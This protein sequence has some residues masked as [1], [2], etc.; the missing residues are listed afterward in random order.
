MTVFKTVNV[1]ETD[2]KLDLTKTGVNA[3]HVKVN[4][5]KAGSLIW[6]PYELD[7]SKYLKKGEN[8][9][10]LT[11]V[12]NLRNLLGP[13]HLEE[14]EC[15]AVGPAQF[16]KNDSPFYREWVKWNDN[17]CFVETSVEF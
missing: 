10:E 7:V 8:K 16:Y 9:I 3:I 11:I 14:G 1:D 5:E 12:N 2:F 17:F 6:N 13:H 4:G 15:F